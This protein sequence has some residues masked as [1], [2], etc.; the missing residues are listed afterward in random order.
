MA[1]NLSYAAAGSKCSNG[2]SL[3][4]ASTFTCETYGRLYNWE[5]A[6]SACPEG[7][8]L[9]SDAEWDVLMT[10]VGGSS[11]A[12]TKLKATSGW[13][14]SGNGTD[15]YGFAALPVGYG[16]SDGSFGNVGYYGLWWS[17]TEYDAYGAYYRGMYYD[18][19]YAYWNF[20]DKDYLF[21]VRCLQ[22]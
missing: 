2:S 3:S 8:H 18:D 19:E 6:M 17:A 7:W 5:T 14:N 22:D 20:D 15:A 4:D 10:A 9:P 12:G 16:S 21:S 1:E 11:T 13:N